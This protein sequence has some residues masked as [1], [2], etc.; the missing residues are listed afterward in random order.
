[1]PLHR[2]DTADVIRAFGDPTPFLNDDGTVG[3]GWEAQIIAYCPLPSPMALSWKREIRV[4]RF[5]CH[6]RLVSNFK[7]LFEAFFNDPE[8][9][10]TIDDFGGV[11]E[12]RRNRRNLEELSRHAWGIAGDAD[13]CDNPQGRDPK[14]HPRLPGILEAHGFAWGG[15]FKGRA[16]DGMHFEFADLLRLSPDPGPPQ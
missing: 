7:A 15:H 4:S 1:M 9:W 10:T 3:P 12:F 14:V 13:V 8:V 11:Y 6:R 16:R 5:K 2:L